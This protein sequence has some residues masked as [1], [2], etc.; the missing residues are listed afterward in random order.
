MN[1]GASLLGG[2][3]SI[4][5]HLSELPTAAR[6]R[7]PP[8]D[9]AA[10]ARPTP[11][12]RHRRH[13]LDPGDLEA[14]RGERTDRGLPARTR[15][16]HE[17]I[18]PLETVLLRGARGLLGGELRGER[19][20]LAGALEA[21]VAG[22]RPAEGVPLLVGD[23]D[24]RVVEGRLDVRLPV[25]DVLLLATL[26]LLRLGLGHAVRAPFPYFF[27]AIFFLP[28]IAFFG[29]LRVRAF[30]WVRWPRTGSDRRCR[31]PWYELISILRL[32]SPATS[33]RRSPSTLKL[34]SMY[35]RIRLTS[36]S[37]RSRTFVP[38]LTCVPSMMAKGRA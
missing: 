3:S 10:L 23:R 28:A 22:A 20:G 16:L 13:V 24:D 31:I 4:H 18:D 36:S 17:H 6:G 30:V 14:R 19:S 5:P 34:R 2:G 12:V 11:V 35:S 1:T 7:V 25:Q 32:M 9:A 33:R 37:E 29:P 27:F 26:G 15:A 21:N 38:G 8:L